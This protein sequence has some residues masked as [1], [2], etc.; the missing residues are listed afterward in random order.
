MSML[1]QL[2]T[3]PHPPTIGVRQHASD[4]A[5]AP[6]LFKQKNLHSAS[7]F[8]TSGYNYDT[9]S[10]DASRST[11]PLQPHDSFSYDSISTTKN[12]ASPPSFEQEDPFSTSGSQSTIR[13]RSNSAMEEDVDDSADTTTTPDALPGSRDYRR[14]LKQR[15]KQKEKRKIA[16]LQAKL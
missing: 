15:E 6:A 12:N 7:T 1:L 8:I 4:P 5:K 11:S 2:A 9:N 3:R 13:Y 16:R 10:N 14:K